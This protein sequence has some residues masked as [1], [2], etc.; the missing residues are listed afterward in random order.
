MAKIPVE[1]RDQG[2]PW[3]GWLLIALGVILLGWLLW[4]LFANNGAVADDPATGPAAVA[5]ITD[6]N[7]I[8]ANP[9]Q[10][11][12]VGQPVQLQV[13]P[14]QQVSGDRVV[15]VGQ[16]PTLPLLVVIDDATLPAVS[17]LDIAPGQTVNVAG[18]LQPLPSA[19]QAQQGWNLSEAE[20]NQLAG[21][22]VYLSAT[23]LDVAG[24]S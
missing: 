1:R 5:P 19:E 10:E 18:T 6:V 9:N 22:D 2:F 14:V 16:D 11:Q 20:L 23:Q 17:P 24:G 8:V 21:Q 7:T 3:W 12:L 13:V 4:S 15:W